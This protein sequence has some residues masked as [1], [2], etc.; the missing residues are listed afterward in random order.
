M[1]LVALILAAEEATKPIPAAPVIILMAIGFLIA[2]LGHLYGSYT[3]VGMGIFVLFLAT[4]AMI[5]GGFLA[6][7]QGES[8][9]R[10]KG[11]ESPGAEPTPRGRS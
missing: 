2:V 9:P 3:V 8:D 5:V 11:P 7:Q 4:A 10:P 6:Y 1:A